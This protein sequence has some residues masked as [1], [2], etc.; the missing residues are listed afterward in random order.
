MPKMNS[1]IETGPKQIFCDII[2]A[3]QWRHNGHDASQITILTIVYANAYSGADQRKLESSAS[4]AFGRGIHRG[5]L[6][7]NV[8]YDDVI[9]FLFVCFL[10]FVFL[11]GYFVF[12]FCLFVCLV[13]FCFCFFVFLGGGDFRDVCCPKGP[14]CTTNGLVPN[15]NNGW[16]SVLR[17]ICIAKLQLRMSCKDFFKL[18]LF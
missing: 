4:L 13:G 8:P 17:Y 1:Y 7:V 2:K 3:L 14:I 11:G 18:W 5:H 12:V 9:M 15:I 10:G 16:S 6:R